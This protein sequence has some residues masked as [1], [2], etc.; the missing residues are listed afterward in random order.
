MRAIAASENQTLFT[1]FYINTAEY[2]AWLLAA[3]LWHIAK[4]NQPHI[5]LPAIPDSQ[6]HLNH[7]SAIVPS[8]NALRF[9]NQIPQ[10]ERRLI[11]FL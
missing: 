5:K 3:F 10:R 11:L 8:I 9:R 4:E 1:A 7:T 6:N 2:A